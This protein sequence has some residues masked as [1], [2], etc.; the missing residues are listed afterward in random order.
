[1]VHRVPFRQLSAVETGLDQRIFQAFH[2]GACRLF[3]C[4]SAAPMRFKA[5]SIV[6]AV[7]LQC[8]S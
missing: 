6:V 1:M 8:L 2:A 3:G 7:A 4:T 5:D